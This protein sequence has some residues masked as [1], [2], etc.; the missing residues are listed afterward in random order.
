MALINDVTSLLSIELKRNFDRPPS[1]LINFKNGMFNT[2]DQSL[3]DHNPFYCFT[4]V[5]ENNY[6]PKAL[7][8]ETLKKFLLFFVNGNHFHLEMLRAGIRRALDPTM[9]LQ[10]G[11]WIYGPPGTGKS[12][13]I[14]FLKSTL[15][16]QTVE[17]SCSKIN[18]FER[19]RINQKNLVVVSDGEAIN[20]DTTRLLKMILG[21]DEIA[22][23]R[24]YENVACPYFKSNAIVFVTSNL[25]ISNALVTSHDP[26]LFDRF[27][28]IEF[29]NIPEKPQASLRNFLVENTSALINWAFHTSKFSLECQI[30]VG[31]FVMSSYIDDPY[32][33]MV[34]TVLVEDQNGFLA[35]ADLLQLVDN[36]FRENGINLLMGNQRKRLPV[37]MTNLLKNIFKCSVDGN[38]RKGNRR[39]ISGIR[40]LDSEKDIPLKFPDSLHFPEIDPFQCERIVP[41]SEI[42]K[43]FDANDLKIRTLPVKRET[44]DDTFSKQPKKDKNIEPQKVEIDEQVIESQQKENENAQ[45]LEEKF[46][47]LEDEKSLKQETKRKIPE[48]KSVLKENKEPIR[49]NRHILDENPLDIEGEKAFADHTSPFLE[50]KETA[51]HQWEISSSIKRSQTKPEMLDLKDAIETDIL[52]WHG[53]K[54]LNLGELVRYD[55]WTKYRPSG[56][57]KKVYQSIFSM[58]TCWGKT[59]QKLEK[60]CLPETRDRIL[61]VIQKVETRKRSWLTNKHQPGVIGYIFPTHYERCDGAYPRLKPLGDS[62]NKLGLLGVHKAFRNAVLGEINTFLYKYESH[63]KIVEVDF[64]SCHMKILSDLRL[65]TPELSNIIQTNANL[66]QQIISRLPKSITDQFDF[67]FLKNVTKRLVYKCLQGG[68]INTVDKIHQ[69]L[70]SEEKII[71]TDLKQLAEKFYKISLLHEVDKLN[72]GI[73]ERKQRVGIARVYTPIDEQPY[74]LVDIDGVYWSTKNPCRVASQVVTGVE[75]FQ[76]LALLEQIRKSAINW[77]PLS[78]HHD[79]CALLVNT[80]HF[81]SDKEQI[82]QRLR[83]RLTPTKVCPL[84]LEF[85][86]YKKVVFDSDEILELENLKE[87]RII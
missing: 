68:R 81:E 13:I 5:I 11:I 44:I 40:K 28:L 46:E 4:H 76:M 1:Y 35:N 23:D 17:L 20:G 14:D 2:Q 49:L 65:N 75:V 34:T 54:A 25:S 27:H 29:P 12:S 73:M 48:S 10:T 22:F 63:Y 69:T 79:G 86:D 58:P 19:G 15:K 71:G 42:T 24:K 18:L 64:V 39:G 72:Y 16:D 21:R 53:Y 38:A 7:P 36:H 43:T 9:D 61:A 37:F 80:K 3:S 74:T 66:W 85:T 55:V 83:D 52:R 8:S 78:L 82:I 87:N 60:L 84:G 33:D 67:K 32:V 62:N 57:I 77:I 50:D 41:Y 47:G 70:S 31:K 30:R 6:D 45:C 56:H 26:A 59:I 51:K